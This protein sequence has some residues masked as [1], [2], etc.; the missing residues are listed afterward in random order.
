[1]LIPKLLTTLKDYNRKTFL[2]DLSAGVIVGIVALPLSI[3]FAIAS[4][5]TPERGLYT[6]IIAGFIISLLGGSRV[7]IGGPTG[8]FVV[9]IYAI[10]QKYGYPGLVMAT[11]MAGVML[12]AMGLLQLGGLIKFIPYTI[13]TGFTSGIAVIIF[14]SQIGDFFGL[15]IPSMPGEFLGKIHT[16]AVNFHSINWVSL[17]VAVSSL[18]LIVLWPRFNKKLPGS[19]IAIIVSTLAVYAFGLPVDTIG[20]RFGSIPTSLPSPAFPAFDLAVISELISPAIS[21]AILAAIESLLS[22]VVADGITGHKH[23]SN[24]ELVAQ[25]IA[26]IVSP[27]FGG[28][29]ATG[30][31]ART[32][33]NIKN[34]GK[35]PVAGIIHAI[36]LLLIMVFFGKYAVYIPMPALAAILV[37]VAYNMS[38][39]H[40]F[41]S[42]LRGQ[43]S[44]SIVLITTFLI[45][46]FIDLTVAIQV[47]LVL[48]AFLFMKKMTDITNV[49]YVKDEVADEEEEEKDP[50][51]IRL[52]KRPKD[53]FIFEIDG[54]F[55]F[56]SVQKF[57]E[58]L[59]RN[60][61]NY[62][63]L[64]L[65]MRNAN[66]IDADGL[67]AL[68]QLNRDCLKHGR[69]L[70]IS[71]I[72]SQPFLLCARTGLDKR[73]GEEK[74]FGNLDDALAF[75]ARELGQEYTSKKEEFEATVAREK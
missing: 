18:V 68:E 26:N 2:S 44:D 20:T 46:V 29:P 8:A 34:G 71:D 15:T 24:M 17:S 62:K 67:R 22:A 1:M 52:R 31:I 43:K 41:K 63:I 69:I 5:V 19:L 72:H 12:V 47:G 56:G 53:V 27:I 7:Q 37:F 23:R 4:G 65:R 11:I 14:T 39:I 6:A 42:I 61:Y 58:L 35:T 9:I 48:A 10:V 64:I 28:I 30:A 25:G 54:P 16:Y 21:I 59:N 70:L 49:K 38:E 50:N 36:T 55:F 73:I 57:E 75:A 51:S 60:I 40:A 66:Y 74:F 33:T 32:A 45:T 13:V 3:A